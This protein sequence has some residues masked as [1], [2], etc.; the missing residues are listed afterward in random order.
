M[1]DIFIIDFFKTN[2]Q[3]VKNAL[4]AKFKMNDLDSCV[5]YFDMIIFRDRVNRTLRLKQLLHRTFF[6]II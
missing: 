4:Y 5:Y 2:I 1:N 6:Q 3:R